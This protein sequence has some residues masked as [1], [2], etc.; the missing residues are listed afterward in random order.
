[1][2]R[3]RR[4]HSP[5]D[6]ALLLQGCT[7]AVEQEW[8]EADGYRWADVQVSGTDEP[9][10]EA[11][12]PSLTGIS[13]INTLSEEQ[14]ITNSHYVNGSGVAVGDVDGDGWVDLYFAHLEGPNALYRNR[15]NWHFEEI[16]DGGTGSADACGT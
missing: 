12:P 4:D 15:G 13:F 3:Y 7:A 8:H 9:G 11:L 6:T 10:F 2:Q 5:R 14:F 16:T 1:M